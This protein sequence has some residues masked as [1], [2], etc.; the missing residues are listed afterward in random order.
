MPKKLIKYLVQLLL[1]IYPFSAFPGDWIAVDGGVVEI[2]LVENAV[3][4]SLWQYLEK[5]SKATF[6]LRSAYTY[7][8]KAVDES[9]MKIFALCETFD[10]DSESLRKE[11]IVVMDGGSCF[12]D[13]EYNYKTGVFSRLHVNGGA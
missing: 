4:D 6:E 11:F 7:Q 9:R 2:D 10:F 5:T 13:I 8:Y 1:S 12:F 3:E